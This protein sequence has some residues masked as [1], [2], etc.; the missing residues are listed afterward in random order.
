MLESTVYDYNNGDIDR[1]TFIEKMHEFHH[2]LYDYARHLP[3]TSIGKI[4]I[5]DDKVVM[6]D[7][8]YGIKM[9]CDYKDRRAIPIE[10]IN[11]GEYEEADCNMLIKLGANCKDMYDIGANF[12]WYTILMAK[13]FPNMGV[14]AFEPVPH[15]YECLWNNL[16]LNP[17]YNVIPYNCGFSDKPGIN[18][19]NCYPEGSGNAS[20]MNLTGKS[21]VDV[22]TANFTTLNSLLKH[23]VDIIKCD[24]EGA[25]MLVLKGGDIFIP[26]KKPI[27]LI[28]LC[29][30]WLN[31]FGTSRKEVIEYLKNW[32]YRC[33]TTDGDNL[34]PYNEKTA[35]VNFFFL[36]AKK[37][38][39]LVEQYLKREI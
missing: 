29:E 1:Y 39:D 38:K 24:V 20:L 14:A 5:S 32:G 27:I 11:F 22:I 4:E 17:L 23:T 2:I 34:F 8:K 35:L 7:R 13:Q 30:K 6:T 10:I 36:H 28:E 3:D 15:T 31:Q 18:T 26:E 19:I 16:R 21:S 33:F 9:Q 37:H 12:G 25:E